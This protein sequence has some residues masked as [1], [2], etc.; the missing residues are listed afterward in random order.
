MYL[1][2]NN[3]A[4]AANLPQK[5][6]IMRKLSFTIYTEDNKIYGYL[7]DVTRAEAQEIV[8]GINKD[9]GTYHYYMEGYR[10]E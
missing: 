8:T 2:N 4:G 10:E 9:E 3:R 7:F 1:K 5:G 6:S